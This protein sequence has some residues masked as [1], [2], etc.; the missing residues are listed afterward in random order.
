MLSH[1]L[2]ERARE[3]HGRAIQRRPQLA[4]VIAQRERLQFDAENATKKRKDR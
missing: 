1:V 3:N 4:P 2:D